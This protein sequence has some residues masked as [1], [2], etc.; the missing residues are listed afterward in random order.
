VEGDVQHWWLPQKGN[1]VRTRISDDCAWLAFTVAQYVRV[2]GDGS[3]LD[4]AVPFLD[5]P[6]LAA[7]EHERFLQPE[8]T[9]RTA[10]LYE[11]CALA[12]NHS[13]KWGTHG[14]P[15]MGTGDWN[16][17]M[18]RVGEAGRGESVWL[19]WFLSSALKAFI[20]LAEAR[21][22]QAHVALWEKALEDL[23]DALEKSWDGDWYLRAY[24]DDGSPLGSHLNREGR[25]DAIAQ[26]WA[27]ISG[28]G[29]PERAQ[30]AM[31]A[32]REQLVRLND[33]IIMV[34]TSP[35]DTSEP[36]PGY[37][38]G[39]PP[40]VRENG[41]QYTHAALWTVMATALLGDG[42][43]AHEMFATINPVH[44]ARDA[45]AA[46]RYRLEPYVVAADVYSAAPH[47]GRGGWSWYTGSAGWMQRVGTETL[48]GVRIED[49]KLFLA[50]CIPPEWPGFEV[51]LRWKTA[52]YRI[53]VTNPEHVSRGSVE[54]VEN[55]NR[56]TKDTPVLLQDDGA[57]HVI[58]AVMRGS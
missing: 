37:I 57:Q 49:G 46:E 28:M 17:G 30:R 24:F 40:G 7:D 8:T 29:D 39:Y 34:L 15:L 1:G 16:D 2:S 25:I 19:G 58:A 36:D 38:R 50:P 9:E 21:G 20:P 52:T 27:V 56:L 5:A 45:A 11:H 26:S 23:K 10:S 44:H 43:A 42:A 31:Q 53:E 12:L 41:G 33:E 13:L 3:V 54:I 14:L 48:L 18:N 55:G 6:V 47:I 4:E 22:D 51:T 32:V 35:F